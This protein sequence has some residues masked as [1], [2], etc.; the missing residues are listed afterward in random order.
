M[1]RKSTSLL[2]ILCM[3]LAML[4]VSTFT[5]Y[6]AEGLTVTGGVLDTDYTY[7]GDVLTITSGTAISIS[8]VTTTLDKIVVQSGITA[9]IMLNGVDIDISATS[10]ACA[11]DMTGATV[12]LTLVGINILKSGDNK[13]GL[14]AP[15]GTTLNIDGIGALN[16]TGGLWAAGIGGGKTENAGTIT[17]NDGTV[18]ATGVKAAAGIGGGYMGSAGTI[19]INGGTVTATGGT[20][21]AGIGTGNGGNNGTITITDGIIAATGGNHGA[22][23]GS[24]SM[25]GTSASVSI[26]GG[27][28]TATGAGEGAGIGGGALKAGG[29]IDISG[30]TVTAIST[31]EGAGIGGGYAGNGGAIT[32]RGNSIV[33]ATGGIYSG[34]GIGGGNRGNGG[35]IAI[36]GNSIVTAAGGKRSAGVGS[37]ENAVNGG[38]ITITE[39]ST[40]IA[41]SG[42]QAAG[43]GGGVGSEGALITTDEFTKITALS[44]YGDLAIHAVTGSNINSYILM[45]T[46]TMAK[47]SNTKTEI[48]NSVGT[49]LAP[50]IEWVPANAYKSMAFTLPS[51][52]TTYT[53]YTAGAKQQY[54]NDSTT[55]N[56]FVI[57]GAGLSAFNA[58]TAAQAAPTAIVQSITGTTQVGQTLTG[59]YTYSDANGDLEGTSTYK[60]Y[61]SDDA[62]GTNKVA[63]ARATAT[64]YSLQATDLGKYIS[65][66]VT[67]VASTGTTTGVAVESAKVG[68][69]ITAQAAPT[70]IVQS[71]TG[72]TQVGQTLTGHYTYSD[73]NSDAEGM[74]TYKW[75]RSD[76][77]SGTNKVAIAGATATTYSLQATD[78]G[79]YISF[80]VTPVAS[81]GT[82]TGVAVESAKVGAII[83]AQAAPTAIVQSI[84]GTTQVGEILTGHYTYSDVNSD[85]EGMSTY[86]W[87]RSDDA[88]GT[89]KVAIAG[90]TATTYSLQATDLGKYISFEV[91]PVASAG[92][93]TGVAV[94]SAKVGAI[95]T[96]QAAPTAIVQ[97]ITG[98]TQVGEILTGHYTYSDVNSDAE[99]MS[100]YKWYRSDDASGTNKVAIAGATATTYSLQAVDL[101]KYISFEVTPVASAGTTT[102]VAVES[103]KVGAIITAQAAPTAIV[104]SITGTTQVGEI[105]TGH[106]TY[107]DVNSDAESMSTYKWYRSDDASGTNKV[108]I[109]GATATTYSLQAVDLGKYISFEVTPVA[110]AGT[111]TGVAVESAKVG[112]IITATTTTS[113]SGSKSTTVINTKTGSITGKQLNNAAGVAKDGETVTIN[114]NKTSEVTF[115]TSGL[116][117]L[118]GKNNSLTVITDNGTLIFDSKA[119]ATMGAQAAAT[120]IK[121]IVEDVV[122]TT[123]TG[124][125]QAKV[126]DKNVY[127]LT[128]ISGGK[129]IS[130][131]NGG[132]VNVSI[133]YEIKEGGTAD[134][135]TVWYMSDDGSLTEIK[136]TYDTKTKSVAFVVDHFSKY[137]IGY[138]DLICWVSP[139]TDVKSS[140]WYYDAVA[141][142]NMNGLMNGQTDTTFGSEIAMTRSMFVTILGRM[143][144]VDATMYAN[145]NTFSDVKNDQY[146]TPYIAWASDEGI[147]SGT[148]GDKFAPNAAVTREQMAVMMTNYMKF[149]DQGPKDEW[150]TQ[151]TYGDL[152]KVSS[153]AD[154]G[155]M[156]MTM[157]DL[158]KGMGNDSN[159]NPLFAP[160]STSTRAQTAQV[161]MNLEEL[162][163]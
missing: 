163:K 104:Q 53:V 156:F 94:E 78:L 1:K 39:N 118:T 143:E 55:S 56:E 110:S 87:Y 14:Q 25:A 147:V 107:S 142:V 46:F 114:S 161:I 76:D 125:Q 149:K 27:T 123:L 11:F 54:T 64:T 74:S 49:V 103:A 128:V 159:G 79:K 121:V 13:A 69:I 129:L 82:T 66:E 62:S 70:A 86:K 151:L 126:G 4:P 85:A 45:A 134:N 48:R 29:T 30:G 158:M 130:N 12:N 148:G 157:K 83:T 95:I 17:I 111:T 96:A 72:T 36:S 43:I 31:G 137:I 23:I 98:T 3:V 101:G 113:G 102:G 100:T 106:Y 28:V 38:T 52:I 145:K 162:L 89:N 41:I 26:S 9:N 68:A 80:E 22:G 154:E 50:G 153:W 16:A 32:I 92:T 146:Y 112:A 8:S 84:T 91:T 138:D 19:T 141:F 81:A 139:F 88:S 37:G 124:D 58:V 135:L 152:D 71:I 105:L 18:T 15:S 34:A 132:N 140:A 65:F 42:L 93:T 97:S 115:P 131:F 120:N 6:A 109:A 117:S 51:D 90:A 77:A 57:T 67:P 99:G 5:V 47:N 2:V 144:G 150:D 35:G 133:P 33:T 63:I 127:D 136:C 7:A 24:G 44:E 119:V 59:H 108:A 116:D 20:G 61:R 122:K 60:W 21:G 10:D 75:Y 40:V 160:K 155:V 73:A